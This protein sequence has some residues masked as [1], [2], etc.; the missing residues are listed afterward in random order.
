MI[1]RLADHRTSTW[2]PT[3][4]SSPASTIPSKSVGPAVDCPRAGR[5]RARDDDQRGVRALAVAR[6]PGVRPAR[7]RHARRRCSTR[8]TTPAAS[9]RWPTRCWSS[10]T[11]GFRVRR[12]PASTRSRRTTADHDAGDDRALSAALAD[13]LGLA[14]TGGSDYHADESH[15]RQRRAACRCLDAAFER[16]AALRLSARDQPRQRLGL[17]DFL[18]E[19]HSKPLERRPQLA[20]LE[21]V[22]GRG[23]SR[24]CRD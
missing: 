1:A 21:Q 24:P 11:S 22:I 6:P 4:S 3:R 2:T 15:G 17:V 16:L 8:F 5:R 7:R 10:T 23:R 13:R 18:V 12:R 9:L 14:V 19:Q 20:R